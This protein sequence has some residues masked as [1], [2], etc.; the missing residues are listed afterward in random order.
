MGC[1]RQS[2]EAVGDLLVADELDVR[3]VEDDE[4]VARHPLEEGLELLRV[5]RRPGGVVGR[6]DEDEPGPGG[7]GAR[8]GLE[9][10]PGV[11]R[12]RDLHRPRAAH[13]GDDR[14]R[15]ER[16]PGVDDLVALVADRLH[17]VPEDRDAAGAGHHARGGHAEAV[18][19]R[20]D[21]PCAGHVGVAVHRRGGAGD[22]LDHRRQRRVRVLVRADLVD[23]V[24]T[25]GGCGAA[26]NVAGKAGQDGAQPRPDHVVGAHDAH[27]TAAPSRRP[28]V[29]PRAHD[30]QE[31]VCRWVLLGWSPGRRPGAG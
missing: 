14:V 7:D 6:A 8:H 30:Q 9:V 4:H 20:A 13:L 27:S 19:D 21:E 10:V 26:G 31:R 12:Q 25:R 17:E 24:V 5:D 1:R 3:L 29:R 2:V 23:D 11:E 28:W 22:G 18:G 16:P 15:L